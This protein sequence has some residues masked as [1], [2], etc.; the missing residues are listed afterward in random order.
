MRFEWPRKR[1]IRGVCSAYGGYNF[2]GDD[3]F[4][5]QRFHADPEWIRWK[6]CLTV[7]PRKIKNTHR[8]VAQ[9]DDRHEP[10][11]V[12]QFD[13]ASMR[14]TAVLNSPGGSGSECGNWSRWVE[15]VRICLRGIRVCLPGKHRA[16]TQPCSA[17]SVGCN[18]VAVPA[19]T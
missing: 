14:P 17:G 19:A 7:D 10:D 11:S 1:G 5:I 9:C 12:R 16:N 15:I 8:F 13:G 3:P 6:N 2:P 4:H 18:A